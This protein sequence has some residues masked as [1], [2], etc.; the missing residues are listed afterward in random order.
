VKIKRK[1]DKKTKKA[2]G[3]GF[4]KFCPRCGSGLR[5]CCSSDINIKKAKKKYDHFVCVCV[6]VCVCGVCKR[7]RER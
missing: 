2:F 3:N 1:R 4:F 7:D 6:C 5:R